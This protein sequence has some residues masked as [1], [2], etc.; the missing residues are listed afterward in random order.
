M[1]WDDKF[2]RL[3]TKKQMKQLTDSGRSKFIGV[4][5]ITCDLQGS[6]EFLDYITS[7]QNPF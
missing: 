6:V 2:P 1:Y 3:V 4:A 5:D 7:I